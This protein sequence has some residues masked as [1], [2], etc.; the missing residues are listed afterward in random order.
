MEE[1]VSYI[2]PLRRYRGPSS[3]GTCSSSD[4]CLDLQRR[5]TDAGKDEAE[6]NLPTLQLPLS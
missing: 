4:V 6:F 1:G 2:S 3:D 5:R